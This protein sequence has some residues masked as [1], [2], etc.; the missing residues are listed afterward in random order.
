MCG[1]VNHNATVT[2][3]F[4]QIIIATC[5]GPLCLSPVSSVLGDAAAL[6]TGCGSPYFEVW[7]LQSSD[8]PELPAACIALLWLKLPFMAEVV[9]RVHELTLR[10]PTSAL[11]IVLACF[12]D[13][14]RQIRAA[15][16][17]QAPA[18]ASSES[19]A[20]KLE[21]LTS[22]AHSI[23][24][25]RNV[26][27]TDGEI[28]MA[29]FRQRR[30]SFVDTNEVGR[31]VAA[32]AVGGNNDAQHL[33]P[34]PL[35]NDRVAC[36]RS[37]IVPP[38]P[39]GEQVPPSVGG[40]G[41]EKLLAT[42]H[43]RE[44]IEDLKRD[45][46]K[47]AQRS[48]L[49]LGRSTFFLNASREQNVAAAT[50]Q[51][52]VRG[53]LTRIGYY[54]GNPEASSSCNSTGSAT[55][56]TDNA[57]AKASILAM[58][59]ART[60]GMG[61]PSTGLDS[62]SSRLGGTSRRMSAGGLDMA[63]AAAALAFM[64]KPSG[65]A[66]ADE[67]EERLR[68]PSET[69]SEKRPTRCMVSPRRRL[70]RAW[71]IAGLVLTL[72]TVILL[73]M[74]FAFEIEVGLSL[75][76]LLLM[77]VADAFF[78]IDV[79]VNFRTGAMDPF[80]DNIDFSPQHAC[81]RY[82]RTWF[83]PD[84]LAAAFPMD[85]VALGL[86]IANGAYHMDTTQTDL[87]SATRNIALM[88]SFRTLRIVRLPKFL[89]ILRVAQL[90]GLDVELLVQPAKVTMAKCLLFNLLFWHWAGLVW[91]VIGGEARV[92]DAFGPPT[93]LF[94]A[95]LGHKYMSSMYWIIAVSSKVRDPMPV[96]GEYPMYQTMFSNATVILGL[97]FQALLVGSASSVVQNMDSQSAE[98]NRRLTRIRSYLNYKGVPQS[99]QQ[100]V[101]F[102]YRFMWT[103]MGS[104]DE[105]S[106]LPRLP[107][108]LKVQMDIVLTRK[109]FVSI[110]V[111]HSCEPEEILRMV[112]GL[113]PH[114]AL[115]G[116]VI[117]EEGS[118]GLGLFFIMRGAVAIVRRLDPPRID[119]TGACVHEDILDELTEGFFGEET[120]IH[121]RPAS[122]TVRATKY[123]DFFLLP[124]A[125]FDAVVEG[126]ATMRRNVLEYAEG[127]AL[128]N[129]MHKKMRLGVKSCSLGRSNDSTPAA[130]E[131]HPSLRSNTHAISGNPSRDPSVVRGRRLRG[132][133]SAGYLA[134]DSPPRKT[135]VYPQGQE[136]IAP[137]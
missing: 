48:G 83:V 52:H 81:Q 8:T 128:N 107:A 62:A 123:S 38:V 49:L 69:P 115:P 54:K 84:V 105:A 34:V 137:K 94:N 82:L 32:V 37:S 13:V 135:R 36:R 77:A 41:A 20:A 39:T 95:S 10:V 40:F 56:P 17:D 108:P 65:V 28:T 132:P 44:L 111:F 78:L 91:W 68:H 116:D 9:N 101:V 66:N 74:Q 45:Q 117:I 18:T 3:T 47:K 2:V 42:P 87:G 97:L 114:L 63:K 102:Y 118:I 76:I 12:D 22:P 58:A 64:A 16:K 4:R 55:P 98:Y 50:T 26:S 133:G 103:S 6:R 90:R 27:S 73:P 61:R 15:Q 129:S 21:L 11:P 126:N 24:T 31:L 104:L 131:R 96:G 136:A 134:S 88:Q 127:R 89:R 59:A 112:Q 53:Y 72:V 51:A 109:I 23:F 19:R 80:S 92:D 25:A 122:N 119:E 71:D 33:K 43:V 124:M 125:V 14:A 79:C 130:D 106:I 85:L 35:S 93:N 110:P 67:E 120:V 75:P 121:G 5:S 86:V 46:R 1:F 57:V 100:R 99:L 29:N 113:V 70:R 60:N 30:R 7:L